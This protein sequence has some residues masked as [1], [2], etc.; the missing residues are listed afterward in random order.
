MSAVKAIWTNGH[1]VLDAPVNWPEGSRLIIAEDPAD[2]QPESPEE[3]AR[4][5]EAF[6]AI[7]PLQM[8]PEEEAD[9]QAARQAQRD[10]EKTTFDQRADALKRIC[11]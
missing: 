9:W 7:P 3:I 6:N 4:W 10:L 2:D 8:T 11:E 1:V 5:I